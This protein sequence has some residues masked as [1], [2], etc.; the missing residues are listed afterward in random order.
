MVVVV[1]LVPV[2][3]VVLAAGVVGAVGVGGAVGHGAVVLIV[4]VASSWGKNGGKYGNY[5]YRTSF[6]P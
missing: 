2:V 6:L 1:V 4:A 3:G 5:I